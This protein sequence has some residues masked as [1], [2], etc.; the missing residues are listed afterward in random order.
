MIQE[1][2]Y[3][4]LLRIR[5]YPLHEV[6]IEIVLLWVVIYLVLRFLK[7]TRGARVIKGMALA[8]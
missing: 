6:V 8:E 3:E 1:R 7:G 5:S 2:L 4:L